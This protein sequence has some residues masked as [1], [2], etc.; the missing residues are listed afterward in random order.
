MA[1]ERMRL[2]LSLDRRLKEHNQLSQLNVMLQME[3]VKSYPAVKKRIEE[4]TL[5][6]HGWWFEIAKADVYAY[7]DDV[8]KFILIDEQSAERFISRM[9]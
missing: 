4:G 8:K 6:V 1:L 7:D 5:N 3:N 2:G 9:K